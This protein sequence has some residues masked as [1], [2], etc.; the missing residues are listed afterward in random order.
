MKKETALEKISHPTLA[1]FSVAVAKMAL[2]PAAELI[3]LVIATPMSKRKDAFISDINERLTKMESEKTDFTIESLK[4]D[5][6]F[7]T[8]II[9]AIRAAIAT[10]Q[11]E[12][13]E[14]LRNAVLNAALKINIE[15]NIQMMFLNYIDRLT[16]LHLLMLNFLQNPKKHCDDRNVKTDN[17]IIGGITNIVYQAVSW[18][19]EVNG[20]VLEQIVK[21]LNTYG[22]INIDANAY[23]LNM[24]MSSVLSSHT[25]SLGNQ[26]LKY[27]TEP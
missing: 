19:K 11:K 10:H 22:F 15:E 1:D 13:I 2:S 3:D 25:T 14:A 17:I 6:I 26:F 18:P 8:V 12:K 27:I 20:D 16:P 7:H 21:D 23:R 4:D 9:N 24:S 5:D